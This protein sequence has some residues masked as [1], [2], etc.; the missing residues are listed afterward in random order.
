M[1]KRNTLGKFSELLYTAPGLLWAINPNSWVKS[2]RL[3]HR[4]ETPTTKPQG[5]QV[6][7]TN[8]LQKTSWRNSPCK[9]VSSSEEPLESINK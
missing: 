7:D 5:V 1:P 3:Y 6:V 2:S 8:S 4:D 9:T